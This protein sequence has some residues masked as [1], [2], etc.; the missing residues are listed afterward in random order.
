MGRSRHPCSI[1]T[2]PGIRSGEKCGSIC[3]CKTRRTP[4][5]PLYRAACQ[6]F[7][8]LWLRSI[9]LLRLSKRTHTQKSSV[10]GHWRQKLYQP[11][12]AKCFAMPSLFRLLKRTNTF[13]PVCN[14][15]VGN[16]LSENISQ[17]TRRITLSIP[18]T[19]QESVMIMSQKENSSFS[20]YQTHTH[21]IGRSFDADPKERYGGAMALGIKHNYK[22]N[23]LLIS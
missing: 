22:K 12:P 15:V 18:F 3:R 13:P 10:S 14:C 20:S 23:Q 11:L 4:S 6:R 7:E 9:L 19:S 1:E 21:I 2:A 5:R 8:Y 16:I 17:K